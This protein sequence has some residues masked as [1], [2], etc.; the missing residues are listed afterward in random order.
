MSAFIRSKHPVAAISK[1]MK[2]SEKKSLTHIK[3]FIRA[4][5]EDWGVDN[6]GLVSFENFSDNED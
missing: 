2:K 3:V 1:K 6:D 5:S 4:L